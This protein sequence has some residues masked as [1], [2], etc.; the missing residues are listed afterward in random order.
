MPVALALLL[1][2]LAACSRPPEEI[3][4]PMPVEAGI[5]VPAGY[6]AHAEAQ[7]AQDPRALVFEPGSGRPLVVEGE[8]ARLSAIQP[9]G[10]LRPLA[11]GGDN[12]PWTGAAVMGGTIYVAEAG[13]PQGGRIL[14]VEPTGTV[15][16]LKAQLPGGSTVGP[17]AA[18]NDGWLYV[19]VASAR[20]AGGKTPD[21]PCQDIRIKGG[22]EIEGAVP[23]TGSVLRVRPETGQVE[24]HAWGFRD[25]VG[26]AFTADGKLLV[27]EDLPDDPALSPA[28]DVLVA[29][30]P[31]VWYGWPDYAG[32]LAMADPQLA[33]TPNPPPPPLARLR[34]D[35][36]GVAAAS[37]QAFGGA[38]QAFVALSPTPAS[39]GGTVAY[40]SL[41]TGETAPF[42]A[43]LDHPTAIAFSPDGAAMWVA[44]AG[45]G[46]LWRISAATA[47]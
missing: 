5:D 36:K 39:T 45:T 37:D 31:G 47:P 41:D 8:P 44:D 1:L 10:S 7:G 35:A 3:A 32:Q 26:L 40:T 25:P 19:G 16:P 14:A 38:N 21:V 11:H 17:L 30:V 23:C 9:G 13:G 12:G 43:R 6:A 4:Q 2:M 33:D 18:G 42:A 46:T 15:K 28:G 24:V 27:S 34:G 29:A 20:A 22:G